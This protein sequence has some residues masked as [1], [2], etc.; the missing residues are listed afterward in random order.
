MI[1]GGCRSGRHT[2]GKSMN[3][4]QRFDEIVVKAELLK[5]LIGLVEETGNA[6]L[7]AVL[8]ITVDYLNDIAELAEGIG[9]RY[10]SNHAENN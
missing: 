10:E 3:E 9:S 6:E 2:G 1:K 8:Y 5:D 7:D 4:R